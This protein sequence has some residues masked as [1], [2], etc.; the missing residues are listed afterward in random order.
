MEYGVHLPLM[1]WV[2]PV[3]KLRDL[4]RYTE[5]AARLGYKGIAVNDHIAYSRHQL[6]GAAVMAAMVGHSADMTLATTVAL[7]VVRGPVAVAKM[8]ASLQHLSGGRLVVGVGAGGRREDYDAA[9]VSWDERWPRFDEAILALRSLLDPRRP[10]LIGTY[11]DTSSLVV[12]PRPSS[13]EPPPIWIG[14]WGSEAGLRRV[15]R[16]GDGWFISA[17]SVDPDSVA[18]AVRRLDE[19]LK[20][21]GRQPGSLPVAV[22]SMLMHITDDRTQAQRMISEVVAPA[23]GRSP[24]ELSSRLLIGTAQECAARLS[25]YYACNVRAAYVWPIVDEV[26]QLQQFV[27]QVAPL[28]AK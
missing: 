10:A 8:M 6:D 20:G 9:H 25:A 13:F 19:N 7:P 1:N 16:F 11:Y 14:S 23:L 3:G 5:L 2:R 24:E 21:C 15:A 26:Q 18:D 22:T 12:G 4:A 28:I 27:D 17:L